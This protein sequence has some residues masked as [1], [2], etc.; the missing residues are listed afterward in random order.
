MT[1][2]GIEPAT[3][4]RIAQCLKL[5]PHRVRYD[6]SKR[7]KIFTIRHDAVCR[8]TGILSGTAEISPNILVLSVVLYG[9]VSLVKR[10]CPAV[11]QVEFSS[12][13]SVCVCEMCLWENIVP[14]LFSYIGRPLFPSDT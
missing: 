14:G 9:S 11:L 7:R 10:C 6:C 8:I 5:L 3:F 12:L 2:S 4:R 1:P 13:N